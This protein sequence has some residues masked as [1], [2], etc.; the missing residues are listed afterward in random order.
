M[1]CE[2]L[3]T[4]AGV[5]E[6]RYT[7]EYVLADMHAD[8]DAASAGHYYSYHRLMCS[9]FHLQ[10]CNSLATSLAQCTRFFTCLLMPDP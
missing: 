2:L 9:R 7:V 3:Y 8:A 5:K 10:H 6:K 4:R 1:R